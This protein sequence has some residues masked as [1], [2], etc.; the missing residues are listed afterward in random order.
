MRLTAT[1]RRAA[2]LLEIIVALTIMVA[3]M[4]F[5]GAQMV[6]GIRMVSYADQ[7]ARAGELADRMLAVLE[8]DLEATQR[9]MEDLTDEGDFG[10]QYPAYM[11]RVIAEPL[12]DVEGLNQVSI[13]ILYQNDPELYGEI[14]EARVVHS[15]HMLKANPQGIDLA[16]DFGI[17]E[18]RI[19][20]ITDLIPIADFDPTQLNPQALVS[21]DPMELLAMLP[22]LMPLIQE[23]LGAAGGGGGLP[24]GIDPSN[25]S[26][27]QIR[28][29]FLQLGAGGRDGGDGRIPTGGD[30]PAGLEELLRLRD[31]LNAGGGGGGGRPQRFGPQSGGNRGGGGRRGGG[32]GATGQ[33][34]QTIGDLDRLRD[35]ANRIRRDRGGRGAGGRGGRGA[36]G[37]GGGRGRP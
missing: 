7:Q 23:M 29:M 30:A 2:L 22:Q 19:E 33:N 37:R 11:W 1:H 6:G 9:L 10:E 28:E 16:A 17:D 25:M 35:E 21:L 4:A 3:A 31:E 14:E 27:E 24:G 5:V 20:Q 12:T 18:A 32:G 36:G 8:L 34:P 26:E 13:E 15:L